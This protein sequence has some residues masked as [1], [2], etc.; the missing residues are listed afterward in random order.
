MLKEMEK[1][2]DYMTFHPFPPSVFVIWRSSSLGGHT[3][4]S[5]RR[6]SAHFT[7]KPLAG[8]V[9][10]AWLNGSIALKASLRLAVKGKASLSSLLVHLAHLVQS[11]PHTHTKCNNAGVVSE[12]ARLHLW[13]FPLSLLH[14]GL[15]HN[16][17][18]QHDKLKGLQIIFLSA[19]QKVCNCHLKMEPLA[20]KQL[21]SLDL[22][23]Y[24][25]YMT[26]SFSVL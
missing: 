12:S 16:T 23:F 17:H 4:Y 13:P 6:T 7:V 24:E 25:V 3:L 14:F 19:K 22:H 1:C 18:S 20:I 8:G 21:I 15:G 11:P 5:A 10:Q 26:F 2:S 9:L